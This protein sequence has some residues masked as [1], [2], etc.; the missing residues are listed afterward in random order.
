MDTF[1]TDRVMSFLGVKE[2]TAQMY[3]RVLKTVTNFLQSSQKKGLTQHQKYIY[4]R[5]IKHLPHLAV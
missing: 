2:R 4:V 1:T 3:V 5:H